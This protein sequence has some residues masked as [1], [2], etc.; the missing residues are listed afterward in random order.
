MRSGYTSKLA[1]HQR[2]GSQLVHDTSSPWYV[3]AQGQHW[4]AFLKG[5]L[6]IGRASHVLTHACP[7]LTNLAIAGP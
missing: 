6:V 3:A 1:R 5:W 4:L 2:R 7:A